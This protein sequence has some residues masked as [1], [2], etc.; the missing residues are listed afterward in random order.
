MNTKK[1]LNKTLIALSIALIAVPLNAKSIK[2]TPNT[3]SDQAI[4]LL[5]SNQVYEVSHNQ[6]L[7]SLF[8]MDSAFNISDQ[9]IDRIVASVKDMSDIDFYRV[10]AKEKLTSA[11]KDE[12][13]QYIISERKKNGFDLRSRA[14]L[15]VRVDNASMHNRLISLGREVPKKPENFKEFDI[16]DYFNMKFDTYMLTVSQIMNQ[17]LDS[18]QVND[19]MRSAG[20]TSKQGL[21][22]IVKNS[23]FKPKLR[24]LI[25]QEIQERNLEDVDKAQIAFWCEFI[26]GYVEETTS[27]KD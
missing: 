18:Y 6:M 25:V 20:A 7:Y 15:L 16:D 3:K 17:Q 22:N 10:F 19:L 26:K 2:V 8:K 13:N 12:F 21:I 1:I 9:Y 24:D 11:Q 5:T 14:N 27:M 23:P 4:Y